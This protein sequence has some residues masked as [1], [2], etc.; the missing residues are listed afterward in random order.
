[1]QE[2]RDRYIKL[3]GLCAVDTQ[4]LINTQSEL[5]LTFPESF[6]EAC[7]FFDGSGCGNFFHNIDRAVEPN[8]F[9]ET[10]RLR[11]SISLPNRYL[12]IGEPPGSLLLI[13]CEIGSTIW[14]DASDAPNLAKGGPLRDPTIWN[15][16]YECLE[17]AIE[18]EEEESKF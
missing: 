6:Y 10:Q 8:I 17:F 3:N 7:K 18:Q 15:N 13:D 14:C 9:G 4:R 12:V 11:E 16:F 5:G 2:L 1:M